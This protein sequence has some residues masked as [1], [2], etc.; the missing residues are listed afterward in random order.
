MVSRNMI[1]PGD[2]DAFNFEQSSLRINI[3]CVFGELIRRWGILWRPLEMSFG[4]R[5]AVIGCC[6]RL[7]NYCL[8]A[9]LEFDDELKK[10]N[11]FIK[12][13]PGLE[14]L[15]PR[16]NEDGEPVDHLT[17]ECRCINCRQ[18]GRIRMK[19]DPS[20]RAELQKDVREKGIVRPTQRDLL[21]INKRR[22]T[23]LFTVLFL[24]S[25]LCSLPHDRGHAQEEQ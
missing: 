16:V 22:I 21:F 17:T 25:P 15:A 14:L 12:V 13:V 1:F 10:S 20:Q 24:L 19:G 7:H 5:S 6:I 2:D 23:V 11:G 4:H 8:N 3:E 18:T 9:R